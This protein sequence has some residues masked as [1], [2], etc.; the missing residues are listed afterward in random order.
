MSVAK[1]DP[2]WTPVDNE[3]FDG[4]GKTH[5]D[6]NSNVSALTVHLTIVNRKFIYT[7]PYQPVREV[8]A[9]WGTTVIGG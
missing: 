4:P 8:C 1:A 5:T 7:R 6:N 9:F 2:R 3:L